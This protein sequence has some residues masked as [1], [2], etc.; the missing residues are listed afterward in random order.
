MAAAKTVMD[1]AR[2]IASG[3]VVTAMCRKG[4]VSE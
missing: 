1:G 3:T 2:T 4:K